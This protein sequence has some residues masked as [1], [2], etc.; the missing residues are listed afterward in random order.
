MSDDPMSDE[1]QQAWAQLASELAQL[2][3]EG[4]TQSEITQMLVEQGWAYDTA[5]DFVSKIH[6]QW[7]QWASTPEGQAAQAEPRGI[8]LAERFPNLRPMRGAPS[9]FTVN[10]IGLTIYGARDRDAETGSYIKTHCLCFVF[11]PVFAIGA[12]RVIAAPGGGWYFL[13]RERLS[14]LAKAWNLLVVLAILGLVG[15]GFWTEHVESPE[16]QAG[17]KMEQAETAAADGNL[18]KAAQLYGEVAQGQTSHASSAVSG[19]SG[20]LR[21][22]AESPP[23]DATVETVFSFAVQV[24]RG[25]G[26]LPD[27][28]QLASQLAQ[29]RALESPAAALRL[30]Q[31]VSSLAPD[32]SARLARELLAAHG[33][34]LPLA[35]T[36]EACRIAI[37]LANSPTDRQQLFVWGAEQ[38][39]QFAADDVASGV[40]LLGVLAPLE[41]PERVGE[42]L[43]N[44]LA[45][46]FDALP[47]AAAQA[48]LESAWKSLPVET[49]PSL[50]RAALGWLERRS[51]AD[52]RDSLQLLN[53]LQ[54]LDEPLASEVDAARRG[55]L[56][57]L[58]AADPADADAALRL[59]LLLEK[60]GETD[61]IVALLEPL[62]DRIRE[63]EGPRVLGQA[64]AR[65]GKF[66]ESYALLQP[67][68]EQRL[69]ALH[70]AE[71]AFNDQFS[72]I[73]QR[74]F[75]QLQ[76]GNVADFEYVRYENATEDGRIA[77]IH[78]Y[79][80]KRLSADPSMT[81]ARND[82]VRYAAIV[83][84][85]LDLGIVTLRR[86]QSLSD[87]DAREAELQKAEATFLAI[88]GVA[89]DDDRYRLFLGQV[90]YWLG[91]HDDGRKL[92]DELL[93]SQGRNYAMLMQVAHVTRDL[94]AMQDARELL[95]EAYEKTGKSEE[96]QAAA[97]LRAITPNDM[98]DRIVWLKRA[99]VRDPFVQA[100]LASTLGH[101]AARKGDEAEAARQYRDSI[102]VYRKL[103]ESASSLHN[104]AI[105]LFSLYSVTG[106]RAAYDE[107]IQRAERAAALAP[108]DALVLLH[109]AVRVLEQGLADLAGDEIDLRRQRSSGQFAVLNALVT[110]AREL[111]EIRRRVRDNALIQR[112][113][114]LL[115]KVMI[116]APKNETA[117]DLAWS[118]L[119][120]ARDGDALRDL[121]ARVAAAGLEPT[122]TIR[123][124]LKRYREAEPDEAEVWQRSVEHFEKLVVESRDSGR[125]T[126]FA[127]AA[128][129]LNRLRMLPL[130]DDAPIDADAIV[131]LAEEANANRSTLA[132][133]MALADALSFRGNQA[134]GAS[135][136]DW[137]SQSKACR[138]ML[139]ART[140][141]ALALNRSDA[142]GEAARGNAD[143]LRAAEL[144]AA[145]IAE[146]PDTADPLDW[147]FLRPTQPEAAA[148]AAESGATEV[149]RLVFQVRRRLSPVA[150]AY[151]VQEFWQQLSLGDEAA[152]REAI[153]SVRDAGVPIPAEL[154]D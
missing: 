36:E 58:V 10:G 93:E 72:Q 144:T 22:V 15:F 101:Q 40:A 129:Q 20:V 121:S 103:P 132:T 59:S 31:I 115:D 63:G 131:R 5:R 123:E 110:D 80:N 32:D 127:L 56:E 53:V 153:Q 66:D 37:A 120:F 112:A 79:L 8:D 108:S 12:Y 43:D 83:P 18:E 6:Q 49:R 142:V 92:F 24:Q 45:K 23:S 34:G 71:A 14:R 50:A 3:S 151:A 64:F 21:Q 27:T 68:V 140:L 136:P 133:R 107:G 91:R 33:E 82:L 154:L 143:L 138:R 51:D 61:R 90:Y 88:R 111:A 57:S 99:D 60:E 141:A 146:F 86:A 122:E 89:G 46:G 1:Q 13:G 81:A 75:S 29:Q 25:C 69:A 35:P 39:E 78:E 87:P 74:V 118:L 109:L 147:A 30:L 62:S 47:A 77:M 85:A 135:D 102:A 84:V 2:L 117:Y 76:T 126:D 149:S 130:A 104:G 128:R 41:S 67:W 44:V 125:H 26:G 19:L 7:Q 42:T 4:R 96:K 28:F 113:R 70:A 17:L 97:Q 100:D 119:S 134:I 73:Q 95:E 139:D 137:A 98:E 16:Y 48:T 94:G 124:T 38:A 150:A 55:L 114:D 116:L 65:Q 106:D 152:G 54:E 11:L 52:P 148:I 9:M 105:V 145:L